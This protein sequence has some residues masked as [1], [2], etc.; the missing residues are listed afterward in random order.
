L[1]LTLF[2]FSHVIVTGGP[3]LR[4]FAP[5]SSFASR[6]TLE[7]GLNVHTLGALIGAFIGCL[8][9]IPG[10]RIRRVDS[11]LGDLTYTLYL[12][13]FA[14]LAT[15]NQ[16]FPC[17]PDDRRIW[18]SF[19]AALLCSVLLYLFIDRPLVRAYIRRR[20]F[21]PSRSALEIPTSTAA[22]AAVTKLG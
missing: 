12:C 8:L 4:L 2:G 3:H 13:H 18:L 5:F 16:D 15:M 14:V 19:V 9:I 22:A 21:A 17:I 20:T 11:F 1:F 10:R 6:L 7:D